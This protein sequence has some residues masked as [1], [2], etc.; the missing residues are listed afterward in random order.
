MIKDIAVNIT[1]IFNP[2]TSQALFIIV[3]NT[4]DHL[5]EV[6]KY[7]QIV[8]QFIIS[9]EIVLLLRDWRRRAFSEEFNEEFGLFSIAAFGLLVAAIVL[10]YLSSAINTERLY[11]ITLMFLAHFL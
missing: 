5:H 4:S 11:H 8:T 1:E 10:P 2:S 7:V 3:S 6:Q 9:V